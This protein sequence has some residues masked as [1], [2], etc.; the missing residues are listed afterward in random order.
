MHPS[1]TTSGDEF[2]VVWEDRGFTFPGRGRA[3]AFRRYTS[4]GPLGRERYLEPAFTAA[5]ER[6]EPRVAA[7]ADGS[8][9]VTWTERAEPMSDLDVWAQRFARPED[10]ASPVAGE[11]FRVN[12]STTGDQQAPDVAMDAEGNFVIVWR[13]DLASGGSLVEGRLYHRFALSVDEFVVA[14]GVAADARPSV[15]F[16]DGGRILVAWHAPGVDGGGTDVAGRRYQAVV[17]PC[18]EDPRS[19]CLQQDRFR[20]EVA[21]RDFAGATGPGRT[22]P[23]RS[24][25]SGLFWFFSPS[26]W[27]ILV[28]VLDG[29]DVTGFYWVFAAATTNVE[30]TL[31]VTDTETG[32]RRDYFNP[33]GVS[34][35]AITDTSAFATCGAAP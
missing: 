26:N 25:D 1:V 14:G 31:T 16:A 3:I 21:W 23:F 15:A 18:V 4:E 20:V 29:C 33:L 5:D 19:L 8:F 6:S 11:P 35:A 17:P 28:K 10:S 24:D 9:V 2:V 34:S 32:D 13:S 27:E 22:V 12:P 30:Y 7:H